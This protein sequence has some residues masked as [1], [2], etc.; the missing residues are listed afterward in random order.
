MRVRV[1]C[2]RQV[3][4]DNFKT[5]TKRAYYVCS[6]Q[7]LLEKVLDYI[8]KVFRANNKYRNWVI[9]N[10]L[11]QAKQKQQQQQPQRQQQQK[12]HQQ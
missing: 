3:E 10:V 2:T 8:E 5:L 6:T 12:Y 11:Q 9:K 4:L 7:E 1:F